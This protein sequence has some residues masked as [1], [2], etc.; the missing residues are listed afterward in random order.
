MQSHEAIITVSPLGRSESG[1]K[2]RGRWSSDSS[3]VSS[4]RN[5]NTLPHHSIQRPAVALQIQRP[6]HAGRPLHA[7]QVSALF[8]EAH[9]LPELLQVESSES[10]RRK[11]R[12]KP[13]SYHNGAGTGSA[14][15]NH[16]ETWK[17]W[18]EEITY[19]MGRG[20]VELRRIEN[21]I[22]RQVTFSKR[23]SGLLKKAYELSILCDAEVALIIFS[24]RGR[25]FEFCS[26]SSLLK[27]I[28]KYRRC[29]YNAS[30]AMVSSNET[31]NTYQEYLK[32]KTQVDYLQRSQRN[33]LGED[34]DALNIKELDQL[35]NQIEMSL[36]HIR[37]T[38]TQVIIDQL[39]DLKY[40]LEEVGAENLLSLSWLS[41]GSH[42]G[43]DPPRIEEFFLP[44]E[45][46]PSLQTGRSQV[47]T[48][49]SN[50]ETMLQDVTGLVARLM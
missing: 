17:E 13:A 21:K 39:T 46:D 7:R 44:P 26:S 34:L 25:L 12:K 38:K 24:S 27:T 33:F 18:E 32:M 2:R 6:S 43:D 22:N 20:R 45:R 37:S 40:K 16:Q 31:Q 4:S 3:C 42:S 48:D 9:A 28:E 50:S 1:R 23:R 11:A 14:H 36:R 35:E 47:R 19:A 8:S 29:S 5:P 30:E 15:K 41:G 10:E 49:V